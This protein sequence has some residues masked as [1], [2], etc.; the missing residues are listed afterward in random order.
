MPA[1]SCQGAALNG[2]SRCRC[3]MRVSRG[4]VR[5]GRPKDG[6]YEQFGIRTTCRS[7]ILVWTPA[8]SGVKSMSPTRSCGEMA[9]WVMFSQQDTMDL[10]ALEPKATHRWRRA[11]AG[12]NAGLGG[13]VREFKAID[14]ANASHL[15]RSI[16]TVRYRMG[17]AR[18]RTQ[19]ETT[20][21]ARQDEVDDSAAQRKMMGRISR[22]RYRRVGMAEP[23]A[24]FVE[25]VWMLARLSLECLF[26]W[27]YVSP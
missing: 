18:W 8:A 4:F 5:T 2:S 16:K 13:H 20:Q 9:R 3:V 19:E 14:R 26:V 24:D 7:P 21:R 6:Q 22:G 12:R 25:R 10:R 15:V 11:S 27:T 1:T 23:C 17:R